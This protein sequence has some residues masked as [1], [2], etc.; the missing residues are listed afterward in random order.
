MRIIAGRLGGRIFEAPKGH[1]THPMSEKVCGALF[2][3]L[4]DIEGLSVLDAFAGSGALGF[5]ACSRGAARVVAIESNRQAAR[6]I[7][8]NIKKLDLQDQ[9]RLVQANN[10]SW[11]RTNPEIR[12]DIVLC[13]PPYDDLQLRVAAKLGKHLENGGIL[14]LSWPG[15]DKVPTL[16]ALKQVEQRSYGD[17]QLIFY[18]S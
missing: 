10:E 6:T 8:Q 15:A 9:V 13:D 2:S 5:E 4:G 16:P 1:R 11:M 18:R 14:A 3:I 7:T 17:A 12:F